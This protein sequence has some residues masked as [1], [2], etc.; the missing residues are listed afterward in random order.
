MKN[1]KLTVPGSLANRTS[2]SQSY[3]NPWL[4]LFY[5]IALFRFISPCLWGCSKALL[6]DRYNS[7]CGR[8]HLEVGVGTGYLLVKCHSPIEQLGLMDLSQACL[9]K[10]ARR[11]RRLKPVVWRRNILNPIEGI[12][13]QFQSISIN[14]VMHCVA[15][16]FT[17]KGIAFKHLKGLLLEDGIL[18]GASVVKTDRSGLFAKGF[19]ALLNRIG[20]FNNSKDTV[21]DLEAELRRYFAFV[22]IERRSASV[23]FVATDCEPSLSPHYSPD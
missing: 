4:L 3:F 6:I 11:L 20:V 1:S 21:D 2:V 15:G 8:K 23:L 10:T 7:L 9:N 22:Q 17:E 19:M 12:D 5:D 14:Y 18:F 16:N 13:A